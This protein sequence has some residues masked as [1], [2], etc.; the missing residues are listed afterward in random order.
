MLNCLSP[1]Y[2]SQ[3]QTVSK[4]EV[5]AGELPTQMAALAPLGR[6]RVWIPLEVEPGKRV[7]I[8]TCNQNNL[9]VLPSLLHSG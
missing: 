8:P 7:W 1:P 6:R 4:L 9:L 3:K 5:D 2:T